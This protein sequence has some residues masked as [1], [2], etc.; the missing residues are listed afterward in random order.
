MENVTQNVAKER[1]IGDFKTVISE[2]ESLLKQTI[3]HGGEELA[4]VRV[5]TEQSIAAMKARMLEEQ[6]AVVALSKD[7]AKT[8]DVY[9]HMYPWTAVGVDAGFG[10]LVGL[11]SSRR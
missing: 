3:S 8:A 7:A 1:R 4:G 9:V 6:A 5:K 2:A 11:L 10:L